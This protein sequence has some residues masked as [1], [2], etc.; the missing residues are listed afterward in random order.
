MLYFN[1]PMVGWAY[2]AGHFLHASARLVF[3]ESLVPANCPPGQRLHPW[4]KGKSGDREIGRERERKREKERERERKK[5]VHV[6]ARELLS[7]E[8]KE[9]DKTRSETH[10][11]QQS[12]AIVRLDRTCESKLVAIHSGIALSAII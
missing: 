10:L 6:E 1:A 4:K 5:Q 3:P 8:K 2:P 12:I 9:N 11:D 7:E